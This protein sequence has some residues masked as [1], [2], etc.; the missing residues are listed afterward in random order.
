MSR[1]IGALILFTVRFENEENEVKQFVDFMKSQNPE[2]FGEFEGKTL[3][4]VLIALKETAILWNPK[5][6]SVCDCHC[7]NVKK[8]NVTKAEQRKRRALK[9]GAMHT[10]SKLAHNKLK[11]EENILLAKATHSLYQMSPQ[12]NSF[13]TY[14]VNNHH[15]KTDFQSPQLLQRKMKLNSSSNADIYA[16]PLFPSNKIR[17]IL[18][19][20]K[21][22]AKVMQASK[23]GRNHHV[24]LSVQKER[25][26]RA[27]DSSNTPTEKAIQ[28]VFVFTVNLDEENF[29]IVS[30]FKELSDAKISISALEDEITKTAYYEQ[31]QRIHDIS[32]GIKYA[33]FGILTLMLA[34]VSFIKMSS[35]CFWRR[36]DVELKL[37]RRRCVAS[38]SVRRRL[39]AGQRYNEEYYTR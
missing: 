16:K 34:E 26:R 3:E 28:D 17:D 39:S 35:E 5:G 36:N 10:E 6:D 12:S 15:N 33:G 18:Q 19:N 31:Y 8:F 7:D 20:Y 30:K 13:K 11:S 1:L 4:E 27:V 24:S 32:L 29:H 2:A 38:T 37:M 25:A 9:Y 21:G 23:D 14:Y 22:V